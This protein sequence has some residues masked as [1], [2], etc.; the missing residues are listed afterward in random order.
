MKIGDAAKASGLS[1][2]TIRYYESIGLL[3]SHRLDNGYRDYSKV[4][5]SALKFLQRSRNLGF[6]I[7]DCRSLLTLQQDPTRASAAVKQVAEHR[8]AHIDEQIQQLH[9]MRSTLQS[10]VKQCP[11]DGS[12]EC[13]ILDGLSGS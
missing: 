3:S 2:K 13:A 7:E 9:Q 8:L 5:M 1:A 10:L 4:D 12:A 6:S 11:G